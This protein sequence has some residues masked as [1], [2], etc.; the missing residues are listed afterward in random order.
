MADPL[1]SLLLSQYAPTE[2][3]FDCARCKR[4]GDAHVA[5]LRKKFGDLPLGEIARRV[6]AAGIPPCA[7][8]AGNPADNACSVRPVE[9][10]IELWARLAEARRLGYS[11][12]LHCER[13]LEALKRASSCPEVVDL[14]LDSLIAILG[15]NLPLEKLPARCSCPHCGTERVRIQWLAPSQRPTSGGAVS[16][17]TRAALA[18]QRRLRVIGKN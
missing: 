4:H 6:A 3:W 15:H 7:L 11:A 17:L 10:P 12:R 9:P 14:D 16:G 5:V 8:A 13:K 1:P 18:T 2:L